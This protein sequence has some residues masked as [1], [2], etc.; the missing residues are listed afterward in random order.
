MIFKKQIK[1]LLA[2]KKSRS[3]LTNI[4][5]ILFNKRKVSGKFNQIR[6]KGVL[7][8]NS[9]IVKGNKNIIEIG[10]GTIV[11]HFKFYI[12]GNDNR[13]IID[14]N[15]RLKSGTLW[16]ED[17]GNT[18]SVGC[19]TT[20]EQAGISATGYNK[21]IIIG[22]DCM[23]SSEIDIRCGDSHSIIDLKTNSRLN[24]EKDIIIGNHVWIGMNCTILKG[25]KIPDNCIIG[26]KS[27]VTSAFS[28]E[29]TIIAGNPAA[30]IKRKINWNRKRV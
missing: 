2:N 17:N 24:Y 13:I 29:N 30:I 28:E 26:T 15:C 8:N 19:D 20:I 7:Q 1:I 22:K 6:I 4:I 5:Y 14:N 18:I 27:L 16:I 9:I 12:S 21:S 3:L 10:D 25:V 23:F 11:S